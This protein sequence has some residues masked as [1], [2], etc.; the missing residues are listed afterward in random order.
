MAPAPQPRSR[1]LPA[2]RRRRSLTEQQLGA[3]VEAPVAE[4][5][6]VG[7]QVQRRVDEV[8]VELALV[9]GD[10]R[11]LGEVVTHAPR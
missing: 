4:H 6:A 7:S 11:L 1:K 9:R 5:A 3:G 8:D 2:R 10:P